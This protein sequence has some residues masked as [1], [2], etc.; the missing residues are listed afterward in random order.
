MKNC[1][2]FLTKTF[3]FG[4]GEEFIANEL[5]V[6]SRKF[7]K[8]ILIA[9]S[10]PDG[11]VQTRPVP[12]NTEVH[13]ISASAVKKA[14]LPKA[15]C[16]FFAVPKEFRDEREKKDIGH[17]PL[18]RAYFSYVLAKGLTVAQKASEIL[19][20]AD[21]CEAEAVT[22]Y[23]Y[24]FYDTALAALLLK[25]ACRA[26]HSAAF[27]RAHN[28]ELYPAHNS[29]NYLPLRPYLLKNLDGVF[30]CSENGSRYLRTN[31]PDWAAKVKTSYLGTVDHGTGPLPA[32]ETFRLVSCCH[33]T[34]IKRVELFAQALAHLSESG[35]KLEWTHFGG[36]DGLEDLK[37]YASEHLGFM[38]T[39]FAGEV[40]NPDLMEFYRTNPVDLFVNTSSLEGLPVSIME[41]CSFGIP[42]AATDVG[43]TSEIVRDGENGFLLREDFRPETLAELIERFCRMTDEQRNSMRKDSRKIWEDN[44]N[45]EVNYERFAQ[46]II[47]G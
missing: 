31:Y 34:P 33:I 39:E 38:K 11:A 15:A 20:K 21:V 41:V 17:S 13:T 32:G 25:R 24:W 12:E 14:L 19:A 44:F 16:N 7:E 26:P 8:I 36:G 9:T 43:G 2:I 22:F 18:R 35:L 37:K 3:P 6:T 28:Y 5:P 4:T 47:P 40:K 23:S 29:L 46:S 42:V 10:V 45:A 30:P 27:S 1:L